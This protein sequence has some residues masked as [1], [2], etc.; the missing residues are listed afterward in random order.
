[1]P[2]SSSNLKQVVVSC[3]SISGCSHP[4][5]TKLICIEG[6]LYWIRRQVSAYYLILNLPH[7][8]QCIN[9]FLS[10]LSTV[11]TPSSSVSIRRDWA[12]DRHNSLLA[13]ILQPFCTF[14]SAKSRWIYTYR[15]RFPRSSAILLVAAASLIKQTPQALE[16]NT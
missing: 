11:P 6:R 9:S 14:Y 8:S 4:S 2:V 5:T 16:R 1:M 3:N 13:V 7:K 12:S 15:N 10:S